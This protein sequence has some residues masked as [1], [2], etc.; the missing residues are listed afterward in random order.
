MGGR[1]ATCETCKIARMSQLTRCNNARSQ[2]FH[3]FSLSVI[4]RATSVVS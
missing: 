3:S 2:A 4:R 1:G